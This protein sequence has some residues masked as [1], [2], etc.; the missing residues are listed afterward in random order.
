MLQATDW[1]HVD[2]MDGHFVPN[3]TMGPAVVASL[4]RHFPGAFLDCH[5]MVQRPDMWIEP[6]VKAGA[7][8]ITVHWET[9]KTVDALRQ[10]RQACG[11]LKLGL[12]IRPLTRIED[13]PS[14]VFGSVDMCLVMTVEPGFGGQAL[15]PSCLDKIAMVKAI[16]PD[17]PIQVD[18]GINIDNFQVAVDRGASILVAGTAV[19][20]AADPASIIHRMQGS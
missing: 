5:L 13:V 6:F 3:L 10:I 11:G 20:G 19:F 7:S 14:E 17:L 9:V 8:S 4:R 16:R 18:G 1:L 15:L 2:V 12:A